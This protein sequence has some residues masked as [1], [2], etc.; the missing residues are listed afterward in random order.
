MGTS[1]RERKKEPLQHGTNRDREMMLAAI[2]GFEIVTAAQK[3]LDTA[4]AEAAKAYGRTVEGEDLEGLRRLEK[5]CL[6]LKPSFRKS[7]GYE[8]VRGSIRDR[9]ED[10]E[11][12]A[13]GYPKKAKG[14]A[15]A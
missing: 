2:H 1:N 5:V 4:E 6:D 8:V 3:A 10:E 9:I 7:W 14:R 13:A 15:A 11:W 12:A